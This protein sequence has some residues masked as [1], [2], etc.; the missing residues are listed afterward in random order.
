MGVRTNDPQIWTHW[1][2]DRDILRLLIS[3]RGFTPHSLA[4]EV[5]VDKRVLYRLLSGERKGLTY[6]TAEAIARALSIDITLFADPSVR[7]SP[8]L[9]SG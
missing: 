1:T 7:W 2:I 4:L 9:K 6:P 3:R 8:I 5:G